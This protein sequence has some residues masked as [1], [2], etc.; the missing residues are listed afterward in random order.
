MGRGTAGY[1]M[2][3]EKPGSFHWI[4]CLPRQR[5]FVTRWNVSIA[6]F[7]RR[8]FWWEMQ[9]SY[10]DVN[11]MAMGSTGAKGVA[12]APCG[13]QWSLV[14]KGRTTSNVGR[15]KTEKDGKVGR[16]SDV[17]SQC[18]WRCQIVCLLNRCHD[19]ISNHWIIEVSPLRM[20]KP[21]LCFIC[22]SQGVQL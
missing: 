9:E 11:G 18:A 1:R 19:K 20:S 14:E 4:E 13:T 7:G 15:N 2:C 3:N 10:G 12:C 21:D 16:Y 5:C 8:C 22:E 17:K 6:V